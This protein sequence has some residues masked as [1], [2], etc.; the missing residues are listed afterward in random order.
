MSESLRIRKTAKNQPC[1]PHPAPRT[2]R[3]CGSAIVKLEEASLLIGSAMRKLQ[4][5]AGRPSPV[6]SGLEKAMR[7]VHAASLDLCEEPAGRPLLP[8]NPTPAEGWPKLQEVVARVTQRQWY[9]S[10][11]GLSVVHAVDKVVVPVC[12]PVLERLIAELVEEVLDCPDGAANL[13]VWSVC[14]SGFVDVVL[15]A[16]S[17][18]EASLPPSHGF[19]SLVPLSFQGEPAN[20]QVRLLISHLMARRYGATVA[21]SADLKPAGR[22]LVLRLPALERPATQ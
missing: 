7:M 20:S 16:R 10:Q 13:T 14:R 6:L 12:K 15:M 5:R 21:H 2:N 9:R 18:S 17:D 3:K 22:H 8:A 4:A 11:G 1:V 19:D